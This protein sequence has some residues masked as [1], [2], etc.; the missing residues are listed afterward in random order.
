MSQ[1]LS[2]ARLAVA[3]VTGVVALTVTGC[4]G[5]PMPTPTTA[6][7]TPTGDGIL[8]IGTLFPASGGLATFSAGQVAGVNAAVREINAAGGVLGVP[9]EVVSRDAG[10][11]DSGKAGPSFDALV[12][13][14]VDVIIGPSSSPV[15]ESLLPAAAAAS[16]PIVSPSATAAGLTGADGGGWFFRTVPTDADEARVLADRL[17]VGGASTVVL[18]GA[19]G[20]PGPAVADALAAELT[21]Q[22]AELVSEVPGDGDPAVVVEEVVGAGPD[23]VVLATPDGGEATAALIAALSAAGF[24]GERLWLVG[25]N[26]VSYGDALPD[27]TLT[28]VQGVNTGFQP[29]DAVR[30][31][32]RLEDPGLRNVRFAAEA[33]DATILAALAANLAGDDGGASIDR[34]LPAASAGGIPCSSYGECLDVLT[35]ETDIDYLGVSGPFDLDENGDI[36]EPGFSLYGY[37]PENTLVFAERVV[38]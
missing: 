3:L 34:M 12:A 15:A 29:D 36:T 19:G 9:V 5:V 17:V 32:F 26:V 37:S 21:A 4:T 18:I 13:R 24:G 38:G 22:D 25:P 6:T 2:R 28:G 33:Y 14:G 30:A 7:P 27:G 16:V 23:A 8:R 35:T 11:D 31:R 10:A 20:R 1:A